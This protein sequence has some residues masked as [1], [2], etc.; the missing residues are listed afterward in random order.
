MLSFKLLKNYLYKHAY[1]VIKT[2]IYL[3]VYLCNHVCVCVCGCAC[4][5]RP[6]KGVGVLF[7]HFLPIHL[8]QRLSLSL[9]LPFLGEAESQQVPEIWSP[10]PLGLG[11]KEYG[12]AQLDMWCWDLNFGSHNCAARD[13]NC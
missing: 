1:C 9:G 11:S 13:P 5:G 6:E 7:Y 4:T 12:D 8:R 3:H 2:C 10:L